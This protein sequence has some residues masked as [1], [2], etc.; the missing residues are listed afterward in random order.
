[1]RTGGYR[2]E[3][4]ERTPRA[5]FAAEAGPFVER[6]RA[7]TLETVEALRERYR[8]PVFGV[9]PVWSVVEMQSHV[10]DRLDPFLMNVSQEIHVL[11]VLEGMIAENVDES[12]LLAALLHDVGKVLDLVGED[13]AN[14]GGTNEP[15]GE[16]EPG[17]GLD[18]CVFQWNH[19]EFAYSRF[20]GRVPD[21]VAW[22]IRYHSVIPCACL[23]IMDDRDRDY[24]ERYWKDFNRWER[25]TK[26]IHHVPNTRIADYRTIVE[27]AFPEP[28]PF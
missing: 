4:I 13:P 28:I 17:V 14:V 12:L 22:L 9:V 21:H 1:M 18:R 25:T 3:R 19:D 27:A 24:H 26:S 7:Q 16:Y 15:I 5:Q 2:L 10:V 23:H 8:K 11:Q 20:E 6:H